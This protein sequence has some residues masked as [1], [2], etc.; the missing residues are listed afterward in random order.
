MFAC[1]VNATTVPLSIQNCQS[2]G[3]Q[4]QGGIIPFPWFISNGTAYVP[5]YG[6][7]IVFVDVDPSLAYDDTQP[8]LNWGPAGGGVQERMADGIEHVQRGASDGGAAWGSVSHLR[9]G[10]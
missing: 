2:L 4:L 9:D 10:M 6:A 1:F 5:D 7:G 8:W 3:A